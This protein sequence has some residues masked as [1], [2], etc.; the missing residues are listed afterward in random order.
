MAKKIDA[1]ITKSKAVPF[2][3]PVF[4]TILVA[5]LGY[6]VDVYDLLIFSIVRVASLKSMGVPEAEMLEKGIFLINTQMAGML[7]GGILWGVWGDKKGRISVL[8]GSIFLYS[9]ANII[10]GFATNIETYAVLRFL[11]GVGLAGEL[12]AGITLVTELMPKETRGYGTTVVATVGVAGAILAAIIGDYLPWQQAYWVGGGLGLAL[13]LIRVG[14][15]E[16]G[17]FHS[18]KTKKDVKRGD[19]IQLVASKKRLLKYLQCIVIGLPIWYCIG[20]LVT[21]SPEFGKAFGFPTPVS[22]GKAVMYAYIGLVLGDL[23]SGLVSQYWK[24]RRKVVALFITITGAFILIYLFSG[25]SSAE[26]LYTV[27]VPLGFGVGYW[28]VFVTSAAEQ[29]GTNMRATV[30]TTVPN[31]VRGAVVPITSLFQYLKAPMGIVNSALV[32]GMIC[33]LAAY[34]AVWGLKE[35]F[36]KDLD[37]VEGP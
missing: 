33:L 1:S 32:V 12:G 18:L 26:T 24:S 23:A 6:F 3:N 8:L 31:F 4:V 22:A 13:L 35:T 36:G 28:S 27:C 20:I 34:L 2:R 9:I 19:L 14:V 10:N 30:T 37:F 29:F 7:I 17:M 11:A 21:F 16:S 5:A 15:N 25:I